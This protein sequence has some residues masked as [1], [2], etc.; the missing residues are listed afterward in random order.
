MPWLRRLVAGL[1]SQRP[2]FDSG[3]VHVG[4]VVDKVSL[5]QVFLRVIRVFPRQFNSTGSQGC[6]INLKAV[7][8]PHHLLRGPLTPP[9]K[10]LLLRT[11]NP[12]IE[13]KT[14]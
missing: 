3:R 14:A 11:R 8:R 13:G 5:G 9:K 7:V 2:G 1:S 4:F 12:N 6:T 10:R